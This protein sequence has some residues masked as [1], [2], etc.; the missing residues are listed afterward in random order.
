MGLRPVRFLAPSDACRAL[1]MCFAMVIAFPLKIPVS[2]QTSDEG[3]EYDVHRRSPKKDLRKECFPASGRVLTHLVQWNFV[4]PHDAIVAAKGSALVPM[5][6][7]GCLKRSHIESDQCID[8][9][10]GLVRGVRVK[11]GLASQRVADLLYFH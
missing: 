6:P 7:S 9:K 11:M 1:I 2:S 8:W 4:V 3:H 5:L 10:A